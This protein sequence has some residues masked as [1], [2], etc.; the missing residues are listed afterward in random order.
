ME[1]KWNVETIKHLLETND[2]MVYLSLI[3]LYNQQDDIEKR[4][5]E[6]CINN[7]R[8]FN[9]VDSPFMSSCAE[10]YLKKKQLTPRQLTK[11]RKTIMKYSRQITNLANEYDANKIKG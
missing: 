1:K 9:G 4:L 3:Q 11:V 10:F 7:G 5:G 6:T 2:D 8:G